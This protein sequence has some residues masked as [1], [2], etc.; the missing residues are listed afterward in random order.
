MKNLL[1][2]LLMCSF[3]TIPVAA[4]EPVL[5]IGDPLPTMMIEHFIQ[6]GEVNSLDKNRIYVLE[7]WATW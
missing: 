5:S 7:F 1:L 4:D 2:A 3:C 6:G